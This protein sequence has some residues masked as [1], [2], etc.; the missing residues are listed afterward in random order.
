[1][2]SGIW[3]LFGISARVIAITQASSSQRSAQ[4]E[5]PLGQ[6]KSPFLTALDRFKG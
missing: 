4:N 3:V 5:Q 6:K 1:M 2:M